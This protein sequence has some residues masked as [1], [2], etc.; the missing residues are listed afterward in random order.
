MR[1][2]ARILEALAS[3]RY[4]AVLAALLTSAIFI[5]YMVVWSSG[6][7]D[8][9]DT[10]FLG[11]VFPTIGVANGAYLLGAPPAFSAGV[12]LPVLHRRF[13]LFVS[14]VS[15]GFIAVAVYSA[16][17]G[18]HLLTLPNP[19]T[20]VLLMAVPAF[21]GTAIAAYLSARRANA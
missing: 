5:L 21:V 9:P 18:A 6:P 3:G 13:S 2:P 1:Y 19:L 11:I 17:F 20:T 8:R 7:A 10:G 15:A 14:S 16:T 4:F 12:V